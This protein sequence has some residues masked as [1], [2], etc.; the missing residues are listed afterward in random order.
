MTLATTIPV[1]VSDEAAARIAELGMQREVE[2]MLE[3]TQQAVPGLIGI[4]LTTYEHPDEPGQ[5][6]VEIAGWRPGTSSSVDDYR[7][8]GE[9]S[10][11]I[12][13]AYPPEVFRWFSFWLF[14]KDEHGR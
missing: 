1:Q 3:H 2:Q 13:R 8:E 14:Y 4:E 12:I 11:W 7:P 6:Y 5:A 10:S 9:W